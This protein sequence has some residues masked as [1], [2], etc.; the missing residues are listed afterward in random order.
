M[1]ELTIYVNRDGVPCESFAPHARP[2]TIDLDA[3]RPPDPD[4]IPVKCIVSGPEVRAMAGGVT[5]RT[6]QL[7]RQGLNLRG[8]GPFP[9]PIKTVGVGEL[10]D[11]RAVVKWLEEH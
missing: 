1:S 2:V 11:A 4:S 9:E 10:W 7:W 5:H 3:P 8:A 6:L